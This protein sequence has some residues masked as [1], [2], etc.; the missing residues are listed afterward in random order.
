MKVIVVDGII[1]AGKTYIIE[2]LEKYIPNVVPI[3]EPVDEWINNGILSEFYSDMNRWSY[4]FQTFAFSSRIKRI[5]EKYNNCID[6][7]NAI[8][9]LERSPLTDVIFM[10]MLHE[11]G[12]V[13][14]MEFKMYKDWC[15]CWHKLMPFQIDLFIYVCPPIE[16]CMDRFEKR[17]RKGELID[18]EY[19]NR[20]KQH[21]EKYFDNELIT[22][23]NESKVPIIK[24]TN[25][26]EN[27]IEKFTEILQKI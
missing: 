22:L 23:P 19:Q 4:T 5:T 3:Y 16:V 9:I 12:H 26:N 2:Q 21:H 14:D 15:E 11:T 27:I 18:I 10:T 6:K 24:F 7:D 25:F 17:A 20:L 8:F 13:N 1:S